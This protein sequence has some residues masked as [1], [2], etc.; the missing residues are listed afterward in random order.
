MAPINRSSTRIIASS[1]KPTI[2][3]EN[4]IAGNSL[5]FSKRKAASPPAKKSDFKRLALNEITNDVSVSSII[6][7]ILNF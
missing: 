7:Q 5:S 1:R 3:A 2:S 6:I 4:I